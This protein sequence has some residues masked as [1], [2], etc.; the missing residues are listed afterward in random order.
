MRGRPGPCLT[1][2]CPR[3]ALPHPPA[4]SP[5]APERGSFGPL[6]GLS[7]QTRACGRGFASPPC[8]LSDCAG[9]GELRPVAGAVPTDSRVRPGLC[10]TPRPP[11]RLRR[12]GGA[13]ARCWP[14]P[15]DSRVRPGLCLTPRPPLRRC[16]RGGASA[17]LF[18]RSV[19]E[20]TGGGGDKA[21]RFRTSLIPCPSLPGLAESTPTLPCEPGRVFRGLDVSRCLTP[22]PPLR[23][24]R[25]GGAAA[26][27]VLRQGLRREEK[28][29]R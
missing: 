8:P 6:L 13:S 19:G 9:E 22:R 15:I 26:P 7:R 21:G 18:S 29:M 10:L 3:W 17:R 16:G 4:P 1:P 2:G 12:R 28:G 24:R 23:L 27:S 25:R 11:L 5:T 20:G 14:F